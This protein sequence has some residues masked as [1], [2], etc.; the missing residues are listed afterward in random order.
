MAGKKS[1][2]DGTKGVDTNEPPPK[3]KNKFIAM[4]KE[5][6]KK[7]QEKPDLGDI[8]DSP[9]NSDQELEQSLDEPF[10][11]L[12]TAQIAEGEGTSAGTVEPEAKTEEARVEV[13]S[14]APAV[15]TSPSVITGN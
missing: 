13:R 7:K 5:H 15:T 14:S 2:K 3:G 6:K 8:P 4:L 9:L 11:T 12:D 1:V 10:K